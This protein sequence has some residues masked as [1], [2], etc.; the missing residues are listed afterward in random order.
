MSNNSNISQSMKNGHTAPSEK[1][2]ID[3]M[4]YL[5]DMEIIDSD[6]GESILLARENYNPQRYTAEDVI[7]ALE[8]RSKT[9]EDFA[10]FSP[11]PRCRIL[12]IWQGLQKKKPCAISALT[13]TYLPRYTYQITAKIFAYIAA[14]T[15]AIIYGERS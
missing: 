12:R 1:K 8:D 11:L 3:H 9:P 7:S 13:S 6:I 4:E 10:A 15:K 14:S 5:P 2:R